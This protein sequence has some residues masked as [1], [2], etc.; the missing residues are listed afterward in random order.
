MC[1]S[2][3]VISHLHHR[4]LR[5]LSWKGFFSSPCKYSS[6]AHNWMQNGKPCF[7][8]SLLNLLYFYS[9]TKPFGSFHRLPFEPLI[10][11]SPSWAQHSFRIYLFSNSGKIKPQILLIGKKPTTTLVFISLVLKR[12]AAKVNLVSVPFLGFFIPI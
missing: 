3:P 2:L 11:P 6:V 7:A 12:G 4:L 9:K 8:Q 1:H 5:F 10:S